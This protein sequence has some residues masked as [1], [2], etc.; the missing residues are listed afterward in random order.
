LDQTLTQMAKLFPSGEPTS[1]TLVGAHSFTNISAKWSTINLTYEFRFGGKWVLTN[2]ALKKQNGI[3]TIIGF[4]VTPESASL[5]AQNKF[6]LRGKSV[7]QYSV[8]MLVVVVPLFT[9]FALVLCLRT[10]LNGPKWPWVIFIILGLGR[11]TI[12]WTTGT[13]A[14]QLLSF[15]LLGASAIAPFYGAWTLGVSLPLGAIVFL[16]M[17]GKLRR[18]DPGQLTIV[19]EGRD[20]R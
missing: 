18:S 7:L 4:N 8:L 6:S 16:F 10:K 2:V 9:L 17:R 19:G 13:S 11:F 12:N 1:V 3:A 14:F 20:S 15:Q 5:A